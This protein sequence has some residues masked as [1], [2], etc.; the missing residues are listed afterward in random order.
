[1]RH[2]VVRSAVVAGAAGALWLGV[3]H[4]ARA[5]DAVEVS[6]RL[7]Y[8]PAEVLPPTSLPADPSSPI[9]VRVDP[10]DNDEPDP[11]PRLIVTIG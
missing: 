4:P 7:P 9:G 11:A 1:M 3:G 6:T 2:V 8:V 5:A 10:G